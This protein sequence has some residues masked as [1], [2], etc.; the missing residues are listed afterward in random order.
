MIK[1]YLVNTLLCLGVAQMLTAEE[2]REYDCCS[3][4]IADRPIDPCCLTPVYPYPGNFSPCCSWNVY[5]EGEFLY[6]GVA[7]DTVQ[8]MNSFLAFDTSEFSLIPQKASYRP[9][10]RVA[11]GLDL[12]SVVL[13]VAYLRHHSSTTNHSTARA[14]GG[15][16]PVWMSPSAGAPFGGQPKLYFQSAST[17]FKSKLDT[18]LI[19]VQNPV[20]L[21]KRIIMNLNYGL[22]G[23]W[24]GE[25]WRTRGTAFEE[26]LNIQLGQIT[27]DGTAFVHNKSWAVG[28]NLGFTARALLGCNFQLIGNIDL[29]FQYSEQYRGD[30]FADFPDY[31]I[32]NNLLPLGNMNICLDRNAP[33]YQVWHSG[34]LG[35]GWG[36]YFCCDRYHMNFAFGYSWV[37]QHIF[38][39][40]NPFTP[41]GINLNQMHNVSIHG[42]NVSGR[43]DF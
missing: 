26:Q 20:Y 28:P 21:G 22:L 30:A 23:V 41:V 17:N 8:G 18:W 6:W 37:L 19:S 39:L 24:Y 25:Q 27:S 9:G 16:S 3:P 4:V 7:K 34:Y 2:G 13:H 33:G 38:V 43:L 32:A 14:G 15:I 10:F 5:A 36:D 11:L 1:K 35:L 12:C 40:V 42:F 31:A 29:A